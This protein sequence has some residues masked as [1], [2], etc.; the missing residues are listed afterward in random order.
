M[1]NGACLGPALYSA[2]YMQDLGAQV[3]ASN[4]MNSVGGKEFRF[5][6]KTVSMAL[7]K[8]GGQAPQSYPTT[9]AQGSTWAVPE[10][11]ANDLLSN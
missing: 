10:E 2:E 8:R 9:P 1:L 5:S 3:T 6:S 7:N 4:R 11:C